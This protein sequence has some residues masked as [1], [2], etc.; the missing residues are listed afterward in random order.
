MTRS[1]ASHLPH[2]CDR[3][4][5]ALLTKV[6]ARIVHG[7]YLLCLENVNSVMAALL[8]AVAHID[9]LKKDVILARNVA[10]NRRSEIAVNVHCRQYVTRLQGEK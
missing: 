1:K 5:P 4:W 6:E 9:I 3:E 10:Q 2:R 7:H 8:L